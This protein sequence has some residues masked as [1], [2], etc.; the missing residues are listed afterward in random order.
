MDDGFIIEIPLFADVPY[1]A[2]FPAACN[3]MP[4]P[5]A[6]RS[7]AV[8]LLGSWVRIPPGTWTFSC[9]E[10]CVCCQVEISVTRWPLVQ[11]NPTDCGASL[12]VTS[13]PHE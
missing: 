4:V 7:T 2:Q 12:S 8:R 9:C 3:L 13:K 10:C 11:G 1:R 5:V 6:T